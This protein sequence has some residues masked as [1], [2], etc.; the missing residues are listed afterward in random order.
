MS[1]HNTNTSNLRQQSQQNILT[2]INGAPLFRTI[3]QALNYGQSIGLTGYHTHTFENIIGYMAGFDHSEATLNAQRQTV[4]SEQLILQKQINSFEINTNDLSPVATNRSL[5]INGDIGSEFSLQVIQNSASSS[6]LDKF[7]NF[8]TKTF[9]SIFNNSHVLNV[10]LQSNF[11]AKNIFFPATVVTDYRIVL[12]AKNNTIINSAIGTSDKVVSKTITQT[13]D[14]TID[15]VFKTSNTSSYNANPPST[16]LQINGK[17]GL[18]TVDTLDISKTITNTTGATNSFGLIVSSVFKDETGFF[19]EKNHTV[20]GGITN[21]NVLA[22]DDVSNIAEGS[23]ITASTGSLSGT[24]TVNAINGNKITLSS[25]QS[26]ADGITLTFKTTGSSKIEK[27][28]GLLFTT[29]RSIENLTQSTI[30][31]NTES[32]ENPEVVTVLDNSQFVQTTVRA[33]GSLSEATD[34]SSAVVAVNG[35]NGISKDS[36]IAG[37]SIPN[38]GTKVTA[39]NTASASAGHLTLNQALPETLDAGQTVTFIGSSKTFEFVN[40]QVQISKY[41]TS[42]LTVNIDLDSFITPGTAS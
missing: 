10:K 23:V 18:V 32:I 3:Q 41:P 11:F 39:I 29:A 2:Y 36:V 14:V 4:Q 12:T 1:Y 34:G 16:T 5:Q 19:I 13:G 25:A 24:P 9:D 35:T 22:L 17:P 20:N 26:F 31:A 37:F 42:N 38:N 21:S 33:D 30:D 15:F 6:V 28:T 8:K 40:C 7:Y 27:A